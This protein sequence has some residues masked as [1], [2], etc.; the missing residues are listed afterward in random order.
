MS[1]LALILG[2]ILS[3]ALGAVWYNP[4]MPTG[5]T[6][7]KG[8]GLLGQPDT[9]FPVVPMV[10]NTVALILV[11]IFVGVYGAG[12]G[13]MG[14]LAFG[15]MQ[16]SGGLFAKVPPAVV[17]IHMA[18]WLCVVLLFVIANAIF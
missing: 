18:Y 14:A 15:V 11:G 12:A 6:W 7:A 8:V 17:L 3:M 5:R 16:A 4:K 1:I 9:D 2:L 10:V 13:F